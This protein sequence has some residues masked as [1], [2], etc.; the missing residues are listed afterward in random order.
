[1]TPFACRWCGIPQ[2]EHFQQ[3]K[4]PVGWHVWTAP[5]QAQ[6]KARML[7]RQAQRRRT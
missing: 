4:K 2:R 5:T 3:W 1:M 6:I 7:A